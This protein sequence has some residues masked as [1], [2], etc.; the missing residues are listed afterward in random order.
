MTSLQKAENRHEGYA[1]RLLRKTFSRWSARIGAAWI[2]LLAV[3]AVFAPFLANSRPLWVSVGGHGY[4]PLLQG[5][6]WADIGWLAAFF[7]ALLLWSLPLRFGQRLLGLLAIILIASL[8]GKA[9]L[10]PRTIEIYEQYR[11]QAAQYDEVIYT[12]VPYSPRDYQRDRGDTGFQPPSREHWFGTE[13]NGADTLSRM[14]HASR[15]ALSI[16]FVATGI[17]L[18]IGVFIGG[19][20]GYF[21]GLFDIIGMRVV[22]IFEAIPTLFL[23]L[24]FVAFFGRNLYIM[25]VIIGLTSWT[26][27]TRYLRAEFL[28]LRDQDYVQAARAAGLPLGSI[29]FRHM[30]PNGVAPVLVGASF[31]VASAILAEATLSFLGLGLVDAPSWGQMLFQA[32][33]F[34]SFNWWMAVFPGGAIFFT[35]FAYNLI[36]D[37]L[38]DAID[39]HLSTV[40]E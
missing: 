40:E 38:R 22:E 28:K 39:P 15:V 27:Y 2:A 21:S 10:K 16:G 37:A 5:L 7:G 17:A 23:L 20:M 25:M 3:V 13:E 18:V 26:G 30:L 9:A 14:I 4:S 8:I 32:V 11:E 6:T 29:L 24:T 1:A 34:S 35:V 19:L 12:L 33:R 36:G 31:G